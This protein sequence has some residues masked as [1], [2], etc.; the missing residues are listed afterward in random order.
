MDSMKR[1]LFVLVAILGLSEAHAQMGVQDKRNAF[2]NRRFYAR[3][4]RLHENAIV[5]QIAQLP[6]NFRLSYERRLNTRFIVGLNASLRF[7]GQEAGTFKSELFGKVFFENKAPQGLYLYGEAGLA[8]V[9][10]HTFIYSVNPTA[11]PSGEPEFKEK[12]QIDEN[13][14]SVCGGIGIGFQ[15]AFGPGRR[16][17]VDFGFGY[18]Y[19]NI[20]TKF[21]EAIY[22]RDFTG[23]SGLTK[24][25]SYKNFDSNI[26]LLSS[27]FPFTFRFGMGY[28]F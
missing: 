17:L 8:A 13:F 23:K 2:N 25:Y 18:R 3:T 11:I 28:M 20:S 14:A 12:L 7:A 5:L 21:S 1:F 24:S 22:D 27:I 26:D 19:Y 4:T 15:N 6:M 10:N 16:T 9:R